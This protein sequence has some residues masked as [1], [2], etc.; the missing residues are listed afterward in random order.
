MATIN[1]QTSPNKF[2]LPNTNSKM[3]IPEE[4]NI[5]DYLLDLNDLGLPKVVD[6]SRIESG[7]FNP[8]ILTI[9]RLIVMRKGTD[10]DRPDM[11]ID[12]VG[13][14]RF[15]FS[16]ELYKLQTEIEEQIG[17]YLPEFLPVS[18]EVSFIK[19]ETKNA[20]ITKVQISITIQ[21]VMY[22]LLYDKDSSQLDFLS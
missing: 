6:M 5:H 16:S 11:G 13:R 4:D 15:G 3:D 18:V 1:S 22:Q 2:A 14:Y 17:T 7:I 10:P 21:K 8:A 9:I 20:A 19:Q 12:I